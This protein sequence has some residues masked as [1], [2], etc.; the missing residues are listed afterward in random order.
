MSFPRRWGNALHARHIN[1]DRSRRT[2]ESGATYQDVGRLSGAMV[3][4]YRR[5]AKHNVRIIGTIRI[6]GSISW[7]VVLTSGLSQP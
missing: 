3:T 4:V 6:V 5:Y 7:M 1:I 2:F